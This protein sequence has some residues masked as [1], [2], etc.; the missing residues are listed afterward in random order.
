M[1]PQIS[2]ISLSA[3]RRLLYV[4]TSEENAKVITWDI[5]SKTCISTVVLKGILEVKCVKACQN[6]EWLA[7]IC[8]STENQ[9][10][11]LYLT[12]REVLASYNFDYSHNTKLHDL[13]FATGEQAKFVTCGLHHLAEWR[14]SSQLLAYESYRLE[15]ANREGLLNTYCFVFVRD[16]LVSG[17]EDGFLYVW[18][19]KRITKRQEAHPKSAILALHCS[20]DSKIFASGGTDGKV[21]LWQLSSNVLQK[22][23]E[24]ST[25]EGPMLTRTA[26]VRHHVQS[27]N[28]GRSKV[29]VGT[30]SGDIF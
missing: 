29:V 15:D 17:S 28:I 23:Y 25:H 24:Y 4:G 22:L 5:G 27:V 26:L 20:D 8:L 19:Q 2:S 21:I 9:Q 14:Y 30:R 7:T 18:E 6:S 1:L 16:N 3:N 13:C 10:R 12:Q 11:L